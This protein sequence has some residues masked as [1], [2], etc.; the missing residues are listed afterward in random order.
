MITF[1]NADDLKQ[2]TL[3]QLKATDYAMLEDVNLLN[4]DEFI[5]YRSF[6]RQV[7]KDLYL[8]TYF[9]EEPQP[10]WSTL[11]KITNKASAETTNTTT[12]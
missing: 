9:P 3:D 6:L 7:L 5:V 1:D 8:S 2:Y 12:I 4:K 10:I 11:T